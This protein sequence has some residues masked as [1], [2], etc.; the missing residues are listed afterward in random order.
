M[1]FRRI[2]LASFSE[3][4]WTRIGISESVSADLGSSMKH[5]DR[6]RWRAV[7]SHRTEGLP[8]AKGTSS[9]VRSATMRLARLDVVSQT[10]EGTPT[11]DIVIRTETPDDHAAIR[12][13]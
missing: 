12:Q 5:S 13:V 4:R 8:V 7:G 11:M 3:A 9:S 10:E 6:E 1:P 2:A